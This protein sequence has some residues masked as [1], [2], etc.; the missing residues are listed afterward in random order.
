LRIR[1][2]CLLPVLIRVP[3]LFEATFTSYFKDKKSKRSHKIVGIK[4]FLTVFS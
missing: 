1:I 2:F 3:V 4:V